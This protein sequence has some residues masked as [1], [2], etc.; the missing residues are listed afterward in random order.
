MIIVQL[1]NNGLASFIFLALVSI[2]LAGQLHSL[3]VV[4]L[5]LV[6]AIVAGAYAAKGFVALTGSHSAFL[7]LVVAC[8]AGAAVGA[9]GAQL[10][11]R[12]D[13]HS[14]VLA[15]L[16]SLGFLKLVQGLLTA[17][18]GGGIE[19]LPI[20]LP[21]IL[22]AGA[23]F[24]TPSWLVIGSLLVIG[25]AVFHWLVID[26]TRLGAAAVAVGDNRVL[27]SLFGINA[28]RTQTIVQAFGGTVA[29][30]AGLIMALDTG[31]R[32]DLGLLVAI[33]A[34]GVL[35]ASRGS[36]LLIFVW[37]AVLIVIEQ[38]IGFYWGGQLSEAAGL[39]FLVVVLLVLGARGQLLTLSEEP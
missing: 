23:P 8:V 13:A 10:D 38:L 4:S 9:V 2:A 25:F 27:A 14:K 12:F 16:A 17:V 24:A 20:A 36:F 3:R 21:H 26:R 11:S 39:T 37:A 33:K 32:T 28:R 6:A 5:S 18:T 31:L 19:A 7:G 15:L 35:I 22:P 34:F 1:L 29:G 30:A